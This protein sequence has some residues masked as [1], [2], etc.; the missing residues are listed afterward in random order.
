VEEVGARKPNIINVNEITTQYY[1]MVENEDKLSRERMTTN[2]LII[3]ERD[4]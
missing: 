2:L 3:L 4:K 1:V